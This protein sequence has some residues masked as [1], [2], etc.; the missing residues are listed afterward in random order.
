MCAG[1]G[2]GDEQECPHIFRYHGHDSLPA[3]SGSLLH[4]SLK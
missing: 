4:T 1:Y 3:I 2:R